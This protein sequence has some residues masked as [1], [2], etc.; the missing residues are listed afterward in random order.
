MIS[1]ARNVARS[2]KRNA[3]RGAAALMTGGAVLASSVMPA[4]A[5][6]DRLLVCMGSALA[7]DASVVLINAG[8]SALVRNA[9][10]FGMSSP[11]EVAAERAE[12]GKPVTVLQDDKNVGVVANGIMQPS[13]RETAIKNHIGAYGS[14]LEASSKRMEEYNCQV[15]D[16][17]QEFMKQHQLTF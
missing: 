13:S 17:V 10:P 3:V 15:P 6:G 14:L 12:I 16:H 1:A 8:K 5:F 2:I 9:M 11:R 7:A 4:H